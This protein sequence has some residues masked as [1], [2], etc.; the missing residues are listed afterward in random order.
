[1]AEKHDVRAGED[2]CVGKISQRRFDPACDRKRQASGDGAGK[3]RE[4]GRNNTNENDKYRPCRCKPDRQKKP[5]QEESTEQHV[6]WVSASAE[7]VGHFPKAKSGY[8][9]F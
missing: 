2:K 4:Q 9:A 3:C 5:A 8:A 7:I 1:M 6:L